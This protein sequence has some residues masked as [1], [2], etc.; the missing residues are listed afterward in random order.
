VQPYTEYLTGFLAAQVDTDDEF[1]RVARR[2][3]ANVRL[4]LQHEVALKRLILD[5]HRPK[6][7]PYVEADRCPRCAMMWPCAEVRAL[8]LVYSAHP[9][10][11]AA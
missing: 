8:A 4:K 3:A 9:D 10:Y 5:R 6:P 7:L 1:T 11:R 2:L